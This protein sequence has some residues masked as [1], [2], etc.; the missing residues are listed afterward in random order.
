[1][2]IDLFVKKMYFCKS[3]NMKTSLLEVKTTNK[4]HKNE[5]NTYLLSGIIY[6]A[7]IS[8]MGTTYS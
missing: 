5:K 2:L 6:P 7:H 4:N 3:I 1:M 8:F